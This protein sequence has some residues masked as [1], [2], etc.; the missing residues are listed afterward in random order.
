M[1]ERAFLST[2]GQ[3]FFIRCTIESRLPF[4]KTPMLSHS[5]SNGMASY[6]SVGLV[7]AALN[8]R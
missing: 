2:G 1:E 8:V 6:S 7:N 5:F 3:I 4:W